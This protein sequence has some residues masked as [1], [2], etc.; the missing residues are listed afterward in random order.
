MLLQ[1]ESKIKEFFCYITKI[2]KGRYWLLCTVS[3]TLLLSLLMSFPEPEIFEKKNSGLIPVLQKAENPFQQIDYSSGRHET[4]LSFRLT[5]PLIIHVFHIGFTGVIIMEYLFGILFF[6]LTAKL[7]YELSGN[8]AYAFLITLA[9]GLIFTGTAAFVESRGMFD[10]IAITLLLLAI[11][12]KK[13]VLIAFFVFIAS[14]TDERALVASSLV[15]LYHVKDRSFAGLLKSLF[16]SKCTAVIMAWMLY[17]G[18]RVYLSAKCGLKTDRSGVGLD[19]FA[20]QIYN[21][22]PGMWT[23]LE[24][25]WLLIVFAFAG[26]I[27]KREYAFLLLYITAISAITAAAMSVIDI[28]RSMAYLFPSI[29]IGFQILNTASE[30][31]LGNMIFCIWAISLLCP[32]FYAC[33][34]RSFFIWAAPLPVQLIGRF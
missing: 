32:N 16:N 7:I 1:L 15:M 34:D 21:L 19:L 13:P 11:F 25:F 33:G 14:F 28:T 3:I 6:Y 29:F 30:R 24:G 22:L 18:C 10:G 12:S 20:A 9:S 2:C 17:F 8:R 31:F 4:K 5:V 26:L 23:G 27:A